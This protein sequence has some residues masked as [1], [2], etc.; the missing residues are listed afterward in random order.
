MLY[1][2]VDEPC[3][4]NHGV[5]SEHECCAEIVAFY[6]VEAE[7]FC[8]QWIKGHYGFYQEEVEEK[9]RGVADGYH[10]DYL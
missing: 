4:E 7:F 8:A 3:K 9:V 1:L 10:Q 2:L 6:N 5:E